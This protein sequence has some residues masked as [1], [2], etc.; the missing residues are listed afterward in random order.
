MRY[1]KIIAPVICFFIV[2]NGF[3]QVGEVFP[4]I[5]GE[6]LEKTSV[7]LPA[8]SKGKFCLIGM[9]SSQKAEADLQTWMQPVYDI[10]M[11]QHTFISI[12][13]NLDIYFIP[14]FT[15]A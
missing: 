4:D 11:N 1:L 12:D 13:Y 2:E 14:M 8:A 6:S 10:F 5:T 9:A 7:K 15:G 3:A